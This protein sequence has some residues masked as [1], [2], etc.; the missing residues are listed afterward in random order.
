MG[1][2]GG[3][4]PGP[5]TAGSWTVRGSSTSLF[6]LAA[7]GVLLASHS[8]ITALLETYLY[9][10]QS[11]YVLVGLLVLPAGRAVFTISS[12]RASADGALAA[13]QA[14]GSAQDDGSEAGPAGRDGACGSSGRGASAGGRHG[15]RG[16]GRRL[17]LGVRAPRIS[18]QLTP[19]PRVTFEFE[20][21]SRRGRGRE[22][23]APAAPRWLQHAAAAA[24]HFD[25]AS[26]EPLPS[27][28]LR[29][30]CG[31]RQGSP[32]PAAA[33]SA[34]SSAGGCG[35]SASAS[36]SASAAAAAEIEAAGG[37]VVDGRELCGVVAAPCEATASLG[38]D[39]LPADCGAAVAAAVS[40]THLLQFGAMLGERSCR[41]ALAR[42]EAAGPVGSGAGSLYGAPDTDAFFSPWDP[43]VQ[44][45]APG[46]LYWGWR[47]PLRRGLFM[48]MTRSVFLGVTPAELR[49]FM[50]DDAC[51]VRWDRSMAA[52]HPA[53]RSSR[54]ARAPQRETDVLFASVRFPKPLASRS[55]T[56][57]RRAWARACDGGA[58]I[59]SRACAPPGGAGPAPR[60]VG[61]GDYSSGAVIRAPAPA[62][63]GGRAG[64]AAEVL[65]IYFEDSHVRAGFANLGIK[66]GL[67]P[68][69]QRTDRALRSYLRNGG[70]VDCDCGGGGDGARDGAPATPRGRGVDADAG[71]GGGAGGKKGAGGAPA[72][73]LRAMAAALRALASA[74]GAMWEAHARVALLLPRMELRLLRWIVARVPISAPGLGSSLAPRRLAAGPAQQPA[75]AAPAPAPA[76][77]LARVS[78]HPLPDCGAAGPRL[79]VR[80]AAPAPAAAAAA[81]PAAAPAAPVSCGGL[82]RVGSHPL[83]LED[84]RGLELPESPDGCDGPTATASLPPLPRRSGAGAGAGAPRPPPPASAA[85]LRRARSLGAAEAAQCG[86][87]LLSE[88]WPVARYTAAA[89]M[90]DCG[91]R[92][93]ARAS[94][95]QQQ[96]QQQ[97]RPLPA[98]YAASCPA[99]SCA[100]S[101]ASGPAASV[102]AHSCGS[103]GARAPAPRRRVKGRMVVRVIQAAGARVAQRLLSSADGAPQQQGQQQQ[104]QQQ[105]EQEQPC[106]A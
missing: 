49:A 95:Q 88:E 33:P 58:Y 24:P 6:A 38:T 19:L 48:Y 72:S 17:I 43:V 14:L 62:L 53:M 4:R 22:P 39:D 68:M 79:Q 32:W 8:S 75:A 91:S 52:L 29:G 83:T 7:L 93:G 3:A 85:A 89:A 36:A 103:C 45:S 64:P 11:V 9:Y 15:L 28:S 92:Y 94:T 67:W 56:Y 20:H 87:L 35:G 57:A 71:T 82:A 59:V 16:G 1:Q 51:R 21:S 46:L 61:V 70:V 86:G 63:L 25:A 96:Q 18:I 10:S 31:A 34:G 47:R 102:G 12:P 26:A 76:P 84:L 106:G 30:G 73:W 40:E 98:A 50:M 77:R 44:E 100:G 66:K 105:Q 54:G 78:S 41:E 55:Y 69:L 60:G 42:A 99:G 101:D 74:A 81:A 23:H 2:C 13:K 90:A 97:Q 27:P 65:M 37:V 5:A 104:Q 80:I